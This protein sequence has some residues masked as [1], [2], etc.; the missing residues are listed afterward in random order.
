[1]NEKRDKFDEKLSQMPKPDLT[2]EQKRMIWNQIQEGEEKKP[3][4]VKRKKQSL[5]YS[6]L[7]LV[8][9]VALFGL[10]L[11]SNER[12]E[13][14]RMGNEEPLE[15]EDAPQLEVFQYD[16][17]HIGTYVGYHVGVGKILGSIEG[18][19]TIENGFSLTDQIITVHY[20]PNET[21]FDDERTLEQKLLY[22][23]LYLSIFVPNAKG[24]HFTV[25]DYSF[26]LSREEMENVMSEKLVDYPQH[27]DDFWDKDIMTAF[28]EKNKRIIID[29]MIE[30]EA[31]IEK[32]F[33]KYPITE[34]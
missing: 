2:S 25:G 33:S 20:S 6:R 16:L 19:G 23:T 11:L 4:R 30:S 15:T 32:F 28:L 29:E 8:L 9:S 24:F 5:V 13:W 22:N 31:F 17:E 7:A 12:I 1:M 10:L 21:W 26:S 27:L 34:K 3:D 18:K 14:L